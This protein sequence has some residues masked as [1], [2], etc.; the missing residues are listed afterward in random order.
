MK[1]GE[2]N[3]NKGEQEEEKGK[4]KIEEMFDCGKISL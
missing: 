4:P 3:P 1:E 2:S